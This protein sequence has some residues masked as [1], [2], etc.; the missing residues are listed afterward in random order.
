MPTYAKQPDPPPAPPQVCID[1]FCDQEADDS[2]EL[3]MDADIH[4]T[5][6]TKFFGSVHGNGQS[7]FTPDI[8]ITTPVFGQKVQTDSGYGEIKPDGGGLL[9]DLL[10]TVNGTAVNLKT[11]NS[12][13]N[14]FDGFFTRAQVI[15]PTTSSDVLVDLLINGKDL[16]TFS[17]TPNSRD[18]KTIGVDE[19]DDKTANLISTVEF[20]ID[21]ANP[22]YSFKSVK[23]I[24]WSPCAVGSC[25]DPGAH[26]SPVPE[27]STWAM[28][29]V[30]FAGLGYAAF[31]RSSRSSASALA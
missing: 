5:N 25:A 4:N 11:G 17:I 31:R 18:F 22:L 12:V 15:G 21:D 2:E 10:F 9:T 27:P 8:T 3:K 14:L 28:M 16:F 13:T 20:S 30:G 26:G 6:A 1:G 7:Q 29:I 23:Q 24:D 19:K